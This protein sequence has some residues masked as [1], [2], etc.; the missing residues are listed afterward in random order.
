MV[1]PSCVADLIKRFG[2]RRD[3]SMS[4]ENAASS[5]AFSI[6]EQPFF[7]FCQINNQGVVVVP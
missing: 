1:E 3:L 2:R 7:V 6:D 5:R 4:G